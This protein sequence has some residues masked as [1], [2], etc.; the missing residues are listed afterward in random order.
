MMTVLEFNFRGLLQRIFPL[1]VCGVQIRPIHVILTK[2]SGDHLLPPLFLI[3]AYHVFRQT[4]TWDLRRSSV[5][6]HQPKKLARL[7]ATKTRDT[8]Q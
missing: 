4:D 1:N 7:K 6:R 3:N 8:E 5:S 2:P